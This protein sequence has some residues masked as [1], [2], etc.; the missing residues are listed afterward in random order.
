[1]R[2]AE[3]MFR[4]LFLVALAFVG[5]IA[6]W[7][8]TRVAA[9]TTSANETKDLYFA[10]MADGS[11]YITQIILVNPGGTDITT[12]LEVFKSD[13]SLLTVSWNGIT[14]T[15]LPL[16]I[17]AHGS[18]FLKTSGTNSQVTTGWVR[19]RANGLLG[20]S[21]I[22]GFLSGGESDIGG[23]PGSFRTGTGILFPGGYSS[24]L[25]FRLG[26]CQSEFHSG[27]YPIL[28]LR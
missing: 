28:A 17:K 15:S 19:V 2:L 5:I 24:G 9:D 27:G 10:Q 14:V 12:T 1:M 25:L 16:T 23:R 18:Q 26:N 7:L 13:G 3:S 22:Y 11:G 8:G 6:F 21:L 4:T 20:G